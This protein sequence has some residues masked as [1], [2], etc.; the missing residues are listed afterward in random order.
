MKHT[1]VKICTMLFLIPVLCLPLLGCSD[2]L[3]EFKLF[4]RFYNTD[5]SDSE[6]MLET[7]IAA[8]ESGQ[9]QMVEKMFSK[10]VRQTEENLNDN[11]SAL[12]SF[13]KGEMLSY[14]RYGP[15]SSASKDGRS[16]QKNICCSFDV[17]TTTGIFRIAFLFCTV[18]NESPDHVGL[19]SV[20]VIRAE[21]SNMD[22][23][24]WGM[25]KE[26]DVW[27]PGINIE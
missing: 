11:I 1:I 27:K 2:K 13:Y 6:T 25:D 21:D 14:Q 15:G 23:A 20:Y 4:N 22:M 26:N 5:S 19:T 7:L 8:I 3:V 18:N 17:T 9:V 16:Y 12:F 10:H 24:Y